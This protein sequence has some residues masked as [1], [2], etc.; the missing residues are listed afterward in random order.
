MTSG[1][2]DVEGARIRYERRGAGPALL[3]I[4]GA[5]G[6]AGFFSGLAEVLA[7]SFTVISYDR[8]GNSRSTG[9]TEGPMRLS[10]HHRLRCWVS[11]RIR[12]SR[13]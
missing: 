11:S 6:D 8:R 5:G 10:D 1:F 7:D 4:S 2:L 12:I 9:R 3:L 13:F